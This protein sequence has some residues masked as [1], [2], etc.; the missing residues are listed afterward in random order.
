MAKQ[1]INIGTAPNAK[2]GDVLRTAFDKVNQNFTELYATAGADV[3]IQSDWT[4]SNNVALD[5]IKNKPTLFSGSYTDLTNKPAATTS[6]GTYPSLVEL[7]ATSFFASVPGGTNGAASAQILL[8]SNVGGGG[9]GAWS[10]QSPSN[11]TGVSSGSDKNVIVYATE[12]KVTINSSN[13]EWTFGADGT[14]TVPGGITKATG[15][16]EITAENYVIFDSTNG[17]QIDIGANQATG[18]DSSNI[19]MGHSGNILNLASGKIRI[20]GGTVPA[21]SVGAPDDFEG[22]IAIDSNYLYYCIQNYI[23]S[24]PAANIWKRVTLTGGAW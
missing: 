23:D 12:G 9:P 5:Y 18:A 10:I 22:M 13:K 8:T 7:D 17:G 14:L 19:L 11:N 16:L 21:S 3:Q 2:N 1:V 20:T 6:W 24:S 15:N 4:Q